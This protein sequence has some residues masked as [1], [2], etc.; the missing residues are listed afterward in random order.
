MLMLSTI[1][2]IVCDRHISY[3]KLYTAEDFSMNEP[4]DM[5]LSTSDGLRIN[6]KLSTPETA[7][8][9]SVIV[10]VSGI[11]GPTVTSFYGYA[12]LFND[13]GYACF[14]PE[15]RGHGESDGNRICLAYKE[16]ADVE[17]VIDE[18]HRRFPGKAVI[19]M[20][21]SMGAG[22]VI[23]VMGD[24]PGIRAVISFSAFS[25]VE[26]FIYG[27]ACRFMPRKLA[28]LLR[29]PVRSIC[30]RK[31]G[32]DAAT[33][34]PLNGM[35]RVAGRPVLLVHS[36]RDSVVPFLCFENLKAEALKHT[37][38]LRCHVIDGDRHLITTNIYHPESDVKLW[39]ELTDF[40]ASVRSTDTEN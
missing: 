3:S 15:L 14:L 10:I 33:S 6:V 30:S 20:G 2:K 39:K 40:L 24:N 23:R 7:P 17:A 34:T 22:T 19:L 16:T 32:V 37:A 28:S 36:T 21:L 9:H 35:S 13:L 26:D 18:A 4:E 29:G 8:V 31:Y 27:H 25:S 5:Y 11:D 1:L 38:A 12:K